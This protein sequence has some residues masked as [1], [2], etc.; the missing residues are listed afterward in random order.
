MTNSRQSLAHSEEGRGLAMIY[1]QR[2]QGISKAVGMKVHSL[3]TERDFKW[4]DPFILDLAARLERKALLDK[5]ASFDQFPPAKEDIKEQIKNT[6]KNS[7]TQ[8]LSMLKKGVLAYQKGELEAPLLIPMIGQL[9][10]GVLIPFLHK[11]LTDKDIDYICEDLETGVTM[12]DREEQKSIL[13]KRVGELGAMIHSNH[14]HPG[15]WFY[16]PSGSPLAYPAGCRWTHTVNIWREVVSRASEPVNIFGRAIKDNEEEM[17]A[18]TKLGLADVP[19]DS[20]G[21]LSPGYKG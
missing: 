4:V 12:K 3:G 20:Y 10:Q 5:I 6:I 15:R 18:Y 7:K 17:V 9:H 21:N 2:L 13:D 8:R 14:D 11:D 16:S 1:G 19:K